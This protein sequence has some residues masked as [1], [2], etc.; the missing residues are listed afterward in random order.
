MFSI[1]KLGNIKY[2]TITGYSNCEQ[3]R[4]ITISDIGT[5]SSQTSVDFSK[6]IIWGVNH[7]SLP[8]SRQSL[9]DSLI[10]YSFDRAAAGYRTCTIKLAPKTKA[11]LTEEEIA[12]ITAKGYTIS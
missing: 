7:T 3:L 2:Y 11:L 1:K 6:W 10:T 12:Q 8:D 4:H 9:I 5:N